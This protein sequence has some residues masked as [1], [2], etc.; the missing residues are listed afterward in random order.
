MKAQREGAQGTIRRG[1]WTTEFLADYALS[2]RGEGLPAPVGDKIVD[3][4]IDLV[5]ASAA[6]RQSTAAEIARRV[7]TY[8]AAPGPAG[9]WF[10]GGKRQAFAAAFANSA[11]GS[12]LDLDDGHRAAG[13]HPGAAVLPAVI[14]LAQEKDVPA[15]EILAAITVGYEV[16]VRVA[17]ARDFARLDT[18]STGRW[19]AY[20]V[21][22]AASR[23][24]GLDRRRTAEALAVAGVLSPGLSAAGYS[25][26]M[27]N[28]TKEGIP[29][30]VLTGIWATKLAA[31]GFTGPLDILDHPDYYDAR[32]IREGPGRSFA[33]ESVYFKPYGCCRWA[34][35]ALEALETILREEGI[36]AGNLEAIEV[37][38][39]ERALRLTNEVNPESVEAAQYSLPFCLGL[40]AVEGREALLPIRPRSLHHPEAVSLAA[41]VSLRVDPELDRGFPAETAARVV[42]RACGRAHAAL[43]RHPAGDPMRPMDRAA[44]IAK[45]RHLGRGCFSPAVQDA[46]V[47]A[48][49]AVPRKGTAD[50]AELL[51]APPD[52]EAAPTGR[53]EA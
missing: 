44:L 51:S 2:L 47:A 49:Q 29:W 23:L 17:A 27:G 18:L 35:A 3:C 15:A 41:R 38:T 34:H 46:I 53:E 31:S 19:C 37:H 43:C 13:G 24:C 7:A 21:A 14:A 22:A 50:L 16:G 45:F 25:R 39:F 26:R 20:G 28:Q 30:A 42:V 48:V 1:A 9:L 4:L 52:A 11:A 40:L 6:G 12:A 36:P 33:V 32:R 10:G 5:G 8:F